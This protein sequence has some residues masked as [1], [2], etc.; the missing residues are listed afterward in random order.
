MRED[1]KSDR[2]AAELE[3]RIL[4]GELEPGERLPTTDELCEQLGVS[5]SAVRDAMR[6]LAAQGLVSVRQGH[7]MTVAAADDSAFAR[8]LVILLARSDVTMSQVLEARELLELS[9]LP[10]IVA[11]AEDA[12]SD[13]LAKD[14]DGFASAVAKRDWSE[15]ER[16]HLA[17]HYDLLRAAHQP[18]LDVILRPMQE[19]ILVSSAPPRTTAEEDWAVET[20]RPILE[21]LRARDLA[22]AQEAMRA[23]FLVAKTGSQFEAFVKK[24]FRAVLAEGKRPS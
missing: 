15:A 13:L 6:S 14:L 11:R 4:S 22:A 8:A 1:L 17:F 2:I 20:H 12:D 9:L 16:T 21:A 10:E 19:V 18:A 5:R 24:P 23:H 3:R 7:G